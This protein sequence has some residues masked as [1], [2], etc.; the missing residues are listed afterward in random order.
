[1]ANKFKDVMSETHNQD[2]I[3]WLEGV[4]QQ[5]LY[6][7]NKY[8]S[9][10][11]SDYTNVQIPVL[12]VLNNG[13]PDLSEDNDQKVKALANTFFPPPPITLFVPPHQ[14][15]PVPLKGPR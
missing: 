12:R 9:S 8:I 1:M 11:P 4:S 14:E 2:W 6:L 3:D 5:D 10:E 7:A 15:Y 13:L